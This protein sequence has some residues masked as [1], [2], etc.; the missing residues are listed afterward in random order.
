VPPQAALAR[1]KRRAEF[2]RVAAARRKFVTPGA[3]VQ[4][5][6]RAPSDGDAARI[7]FTATRTVGSAVVRNRARRRLKE[8]A[9]AAADAAAPG[10]D[11]VVIARAGTLDRR[12][13]DLIGDVRQAF[14]ALARAATE[15]GAMGRGATGRES[16]RDMEARR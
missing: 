8:A 1:L 15:R 12:F 13:E 11:Y 3:V 14:A 5:A 2:L 9:R 7:G 16:R 6:S 10:V 4:A